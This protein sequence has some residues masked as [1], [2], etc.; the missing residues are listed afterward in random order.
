MVQK[1]GLC[2]TA[3][4]PVSTRGSEALSIACPSLWGWLDMHCHLLEVGGHSL[5]FT[6]LSGPAG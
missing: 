1:R 3:R 4:V 5:S 2:V 6:H